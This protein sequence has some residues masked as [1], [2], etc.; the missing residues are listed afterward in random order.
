MFPS[1]Y[2]FHLQLFISL[3]GISHRHP[4]FDSKMEGVKMMR[5]SHRLLVVESRECPLYNEADVVFIRQNPYFILDSYKKP[6]HKHA[7]SPLHAPNLM[8]QSYI[9]TA[10]YR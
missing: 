9:K 5:P 1:S 6:W 7:I 4:T 3:I 2:T 8:L 10:E